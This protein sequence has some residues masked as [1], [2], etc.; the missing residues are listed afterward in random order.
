MHYLKCLLFTV[1]LA[2]GYVIAFAGTVKGK[3][4]DAKTGEPLIGAT[5]TLIGSGKKLT[6]SVN[7][8]GSYIF[9]NVP[10]GKYKIKINFAGYKSQEDLVA[11]VKSAYDIV[12]AGA[13]LKEDVT[14]LNG[15]E[16]TGYKSKESA[17]A[18]RTI[19]KNSDI[20][21][22]IMSAKTIELSPDVTVAN[23]LQ[24]MSG[25]SF[26]SSRSG[27]GRFAIIR[28]MD[29]RYNTTLVNGIEIPSPNDQSRFVPMNVFPADILQRLEV[30]KTLTPNMEANAIGGVMNL[31]MKD[32]P[33]K[34][35]FKVFVAGGTNT[36][37]GNNGSYTGFYHSTIN[38]TSPYEQN[39]TQ[40]VSQ[41]NFPGSNLTLYSKS[42][43]I[44]L[45]TGLTYGNRYLNKKL[46]FV[47]SLSYQDLFRATDQQLIAR[48]ANSTAIP[49]S[50][51]THGDT[52]NN[53]P[54]FDDVYHN[55]IFTEQKRFALN[56]KIDYVINNRNKISLYN[57]Y[58]HM[59]EFQTRLQ[60]DTNI[61]TGELDY[62][63]RTLWIIQSIYN[64][65]LHG[66]H[67][68][69][70]RVSL[71]WSAAYSLAKQNQPDYASFT[72]KNS[73]D[74]ANSVANSH[75]YGQD[76][77][78][79]GSMSRSWE[80]NKD[81][82]VAAYLNLILKRSIA[83]R[84]VQFDFGGMYRHKNRDNFYWAYSLSPSSKK[85]Y[86]YSNNYSINDSV[87]YKTS[88]NDTIGSGGQARN[89][90]IVEDVSGG[91]AQAK[92]MATPQLQVLGG[93]RLET[94]D[95]TYSTDLSVLDNGKTGHIYYYDILP[96]LH[97]KY[98]IKNGQEVRAS[99]FRSLI[100]PSFGEIIPY[101][102]PAT[103][104]DAYASQG[105][106]YLKHTTADNFDIRYG[107]YPAKSSDEFLVGAFLKNI[108]NPVE[109]GFQAKNVTI[110]DNLTSN[111]GSIIL[112]P[113]NVGTV[114]NEGLEFLGVKYFGHFGISANYT[115]TH[116]ATTQQKLF[117]YYD[118]LK[119]Q[120]SKFIN[121]VRP[122]QGQAANIGNVSLLYKNKKIGL[123]MQLAYV[124]TG[125]RIQY[126]S[127]F[128]NLDTWQSPFGQLDFSFT[129]RFN[130]RFELYGKV[131]NITNEHTSYYIK[132]PYYSYNGYNN[133][134][135]FQDNPSK[136]ILVEKDVFKTSIFLGVRYKF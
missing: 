63:T 85:V 75:F 30:I 24:R 15:V 90:S 100:R 43:P 136:H 115:Y 18:A 65:T 73:Y 69:A 37:F 83:K 16:V 121:Q 26:A 13:E 95:Q 107:Y 45:Q 89:Y 36:F 114:T 124:Y 102:I 56:N 80:H 111:L 134:I 78:T 38:K 97:L 96:S 113:I 117:V 123:D 31:V 41:S 131:L 48:D 82:D 76:T 133:S 42:R 87:P 17:E 92:F 3:V 106:P 14:E 67:Q 59:D 128:Y 135:P 108:Y 10:V 101:N 49:N 130:K 91:Y 79:S 122:L 52:L 7:L 116:S 25:V 112:T 71:N 33:N 34:E 19:Q 47:L 20:V 60:S 32:A 8:D 44:D 72:Y 2:F 93:V 39:P 110:P 104:N 57:L 125:E 94:T 119:G 35:E 98:D 62:S 103:Q 4:T 127:N 132:T 12:V 109:V 118:P 11:E 9:R 40:A 27:E 84:E 6:T 1:F 22:N 55:R 46:G 81:Q 120:Q 99:Y 51:G 86:D 68:L 74:V 61:T 58:V 29:A 64:S 54:L 50:Y 88:S 66:E 28:G 53:Y 129:K 70:P 5:V 105:N 77:G 23:S 21:T 126:V